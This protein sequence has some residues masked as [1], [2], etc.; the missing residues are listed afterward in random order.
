MKA[1]RLFR[2]GKRKATAKYSKHGN[3]ARRHRT[4]A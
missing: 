2:S 4:G 3:T 1:Q